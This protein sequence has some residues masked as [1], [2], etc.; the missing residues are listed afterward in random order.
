M[1]IGTPLGVCVNCAAPIA[2]GM[3]KGGSRVETA[4]GTLFSSPTFNVIVLGIV[5]TLFPWYLAALK[6]LA[7]LFTVLVV[8]PW[9]ARL[10][11]RPGWTRARPVEARLPGLSGFQKLE[12]VLGTTDL[13]GGATGSTARPAAGTGL[14][15]SPLRPAPGAGVAHCPA[16][17]ALAG[18]LGAVLVEILPWNLLNHLSR[19]DGGVANGVML[20]LVAAFGVLLP[21]P[22]AFD[23]VVCSVS[24]TLECRCTWSRSC[25]SR[26]GP[27]ASTPGA[28]SGRRRPG[29]SP[30][31]PR[32]P[33]WSSAW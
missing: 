18:L 23:V 30:A 20:F 19:V 13:G 7:G 1:M 31:W 21:V 6:I 4:L 32:R 14:G 9:L 15:G 29:G 11:E 22:M 33:S 24:S 17:D 26:S 25:W 27:T 16:A 10:A 2:Q 5:F 8:V 28:C 12:S 3:L